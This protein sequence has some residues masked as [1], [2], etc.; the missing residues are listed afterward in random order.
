[1]LTGP[2]SSR[3]IRAGA[4]ATMLEGTPETYWSADAD[5]LV[6]QRGSTRDGLT[7]TEAIRRLREYG[8]NQVREHRRLTRTRVLVNQIRNPLLLVL[9]FAAMASAMTGEWVDAVIV[10][11]IVLA[12]V[13]IGYAREYHA[14]TAA[15]ALQARVR[16]RA[17]VLRDGHAVNVPTEEVVPGDVV[18]LSAG[19]LVSADGVILEATDFFVSEAVLTGESFPVEK[20][21]GTVSPTAGL[22]DRL[23]CV[24]L[25]TNGERHREQQRLD[26]WPAVQLGATASCAPRA[27]VL[28]KTICLGP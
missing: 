10:V 4:A 19:S 5:M 18:L 7:V 27:E 24:F 6:Q 23:N 17:R 25:G 8:P 1:M 21:P 15:A 22:R 13:S 12:T 26:R 9:V 16:T 20:R 2:W 28:P 11:V 14:E 3:R